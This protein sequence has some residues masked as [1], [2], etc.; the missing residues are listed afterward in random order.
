MTRSTILLGAAVTV[1][2][3]GNII[4]FT[5]RR[6]K[7]QRTM[8]P[9][10]YA[11]DA[12]TW[13]QW[14][15]IS[16][17]AAT[18]LFNSGDVFLVFPSATLAHHALEMYLKSALIAEGATVFDPYKVRFLDPSVKL[19]ATDCVWDHKLVR[20]A[21][22]LAKRRPDF[23]LSATLATPAPD[24]TGALNVEQGFATFDPFFSEL[25]YPQELKI[26]EGVGEQEKPLLDELVR[27]LQPFLPTT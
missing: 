22:Q 18:H 16:Y 27:R 17:K 23:D 19:K 2:I 1:S 12:K 11:R 14:A 6:R 13:K 4:Q 9:D 20:L 5:A 26:L 15:K 7:G 10:T 3:I 21:R 24:L 8:K 25:R